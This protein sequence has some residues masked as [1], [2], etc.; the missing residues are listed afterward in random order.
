MNIKEIK[1]ALRRNVVRAIG[2]IFH[3]LND[4]LSKN[5]FVEWVDQAERDLGWTEADWAAKASLPEEILR[6]ARQG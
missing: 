5:T 3:W 6:H 2:S 1:Y 4:S